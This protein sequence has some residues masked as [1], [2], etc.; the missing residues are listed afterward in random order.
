M[1]ARD[2]RDA[3]I[4]VLDLMNSD[5]PSP[6]I[7]FLRAL[8]RD[9]SFRGKLIALGASPH[10]SGLYLKGLA[11]DTVI[12]PPGAVAADFLRS[13]LDIHSRAPVDILVP[14]SSRSVKPVSRVQR[15]LEAAGIA[16]PIAS[17][18]ALAACDE[19]RPLR[20]PRHGRLEM[21]QP[22]A[23]SPE[24]TKFGQEKLWVQTEKGAKYV[25]TS[26]GQL[27]W[28]RRWQGD[29]AEILWQTEPTGNAVQAS[30]VALPDGRL[31][32]VGAM[33]VISAAEDGTFWLGASFADPDIP[34]LMRQ[35]I[36]AFA[37]RGPL[38]ADFIRKDDGCYALMRAL[39]VLPSWIEA[40]ATRAGSMAGAIAAAALDNGW[41]RTIKLPAGRLVAH[42]AHDLAIDM[43]Q[44]AAFSQQLPPPSH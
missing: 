38:T 37:W 25:I 39:P 20:K 31:A 5:Q 13:I 34:V 35:L 29:D 8:R 41:P 15:E 10:D 17:P 21:R 9:P 43:N 14:G 40:C 44:F 28:F 2:W 42:Y 36:R 6:G 24:E 16:V 7:S 18:A 19:L 3:T 27:Y 26:P 4:A 22:A 23:E 11:D 12:V 30:A 32:A 33:N 1:S